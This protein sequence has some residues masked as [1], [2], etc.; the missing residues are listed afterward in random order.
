LPQSDSPGNTCESF[1]WSLIDLGVP[2]LL[3]AV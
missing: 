1:S 2:S 3:W